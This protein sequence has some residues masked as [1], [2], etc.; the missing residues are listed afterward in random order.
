MKQCPHCKID[1]ELGQCIDYNDPNLRFEYTPYSKGILV[2]CY[3]CP[4]CGHSEDK[5]SNC[6]YE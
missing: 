5:E 6:K 1:L 2:S 4:K 3:K